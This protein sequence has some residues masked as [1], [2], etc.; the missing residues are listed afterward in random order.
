MVV[1]ID[2]SM[3]LMISIAKVLPSRWIYL[4]RQ[5][6]LYELSIKSLNGGE[7]QSKYAVIM[8]PNTLVN[9]WKNGLITT[10]Y[11]WCLFNQETLSKMLILNGITVR[12]GMIG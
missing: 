5:N 7:N 11:N 4:C 3:Y 10:R 8:A 12:L 2:Y 6:G 1:A 9:C